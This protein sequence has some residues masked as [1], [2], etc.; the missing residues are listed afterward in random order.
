MKAIMYMQMSIGAPKTLPK[1]AVV[2]ERIARW[3]S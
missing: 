2:A 1:R 3:V